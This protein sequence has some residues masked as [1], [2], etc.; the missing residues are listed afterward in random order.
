MAGTELET[1]YLRTRRRNYVV[2]VALLTVACAIAF[3]SI[4]CSR[5]SGLTMDVALD[6]LIK[7]LAGT[8]YGEYYFD[9][10]VW[11]Y[12]VPRAVAGVVVGAGLAVGGCIMQSLMRNPLADP[13]TTGVASGASFGAALFIM[14]GFSIVGTSDY[15]LGITANA[16]A[17][18]VIP[19]AAIVLISKKKTITPTT[20]ILAG[21]AIMY[22]FRASTSLMTL[23]ADPEYVEIL[24]RWNVGTLTDVEWE[25]LPLIVGTVAVSCVL[26]MLLS[27]DVTMMNAGDRSAMS[28][29]VRTRLVRVAALA[30]LA[31]L[32]AVIVGYT[33]TIGFMGLVAP[34]IAR[35]FVGSNLKYLVPAS[36]AFGAVILVVCD[37]VTK[38]CFSQLPVGTIT[39]IIGG[40]VFIILLVKGARKVWYRRQ[41]PRRRTPAVRTRLSRVRTRD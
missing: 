20:M 33:G 41:G 25:N 19:T 3:V 38:M 11:E 10:I 4:L 1:T 24:Y 39:S 26:L 2:S 27:N 34:H 37:L 30:I 12:S 14:L 31:V 18:A 5:F 22:I 6:V 29:G 16:I 7:H 8:E 32:T 17:F 9:L 40:P 28:M 36:A 35:M 23:L 15:S 13:Y 21:I